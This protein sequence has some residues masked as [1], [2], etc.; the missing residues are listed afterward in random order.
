MWARRG[1]SNIVA[2]DRPHQESN[3]LLQQE[4]SLQSMRR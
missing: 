1:C 4:L 2:T 3:Q